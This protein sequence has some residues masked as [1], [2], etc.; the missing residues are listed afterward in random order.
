MLSLLQ[1]YCNGYIV[2]GDTVIMVK[3]CLITL[4]MVKLNMVTLQW[5]NNNE[6][7]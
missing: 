1:L 3:L 5:L 7:S 6:L 4:L 2:Y